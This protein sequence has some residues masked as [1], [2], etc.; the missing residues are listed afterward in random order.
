MNSNHDTPPRKEQAGSSEA[1]EVV[2]S[3]ARLQWEAEVENARRLSTRSTSLVTLLVALLGLGLMKLGTPGLLWPGGLRTIGQLLLLASLAAFM[4][5]LGVLLAIGSFRMR[6]GDGWPMASFLLRW[7]LETGLDP[8]A[9]TPELARRV[10]V[11]ATL[12]A[13]G[14]LRERNTRRK[15]EIDRAQLWLLVSGALAAVSLVTAS[16]VG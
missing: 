7:P 12:R 10:V 1:L 14:N 11:E 16:L 15:E 2:L 13:V 9:V 4:G 6:P 8:L 5:A 3:H